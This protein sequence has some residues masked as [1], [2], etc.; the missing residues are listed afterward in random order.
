MLSTY[1]CVGG[2]SNGPASAV[3]LL[4]LALFRVNIRRVCRG[5]SAA[6]WWA[7]ATNRDIVVRFRIIFIKLPFIIIVIQIFKRII[8]VIVEAFVF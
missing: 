5:A 7:A 6:F 4:L 8:I 2:G 3:S 1:V